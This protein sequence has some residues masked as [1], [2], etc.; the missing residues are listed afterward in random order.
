MSGYFNKT[1]TSASDKSTLFP[2]SV[3]SI[4]SKY[5]LRLVYIALCH[6]T[7]HRVTGDILLFK[8]ATTSDAGS[9]DL[10]RVIH[11]EI[12]LDATFLNE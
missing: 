6:I 3:S 1:A 5:V 4:Y 9:P 12:F 10:T 11:Q 7:S 2:L 8:A